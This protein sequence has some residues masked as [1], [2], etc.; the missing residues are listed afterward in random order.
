MAETTA[1]YENKI[2]KAQSWDDMKQ[3]LKELPKIT[4]RQ[5]IEE[6]CEK[7]GKSF[8]VLCG[9]AG[10]PES[11]F[12]AAVNGTRAPKKE[13][14]IRLAFALGLSLD[15]LNELLKLSKLKEL[16][17]KNTEDAIIIY[18]IKKGYDLQTIDM[19]LESQHCQMRFFRENNHG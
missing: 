6:H 2:E 7:Q 4:L 10:V 13:L 8:T 5:R 18:G 15:E 1:Q 14:I 16:Y 3:V 17:A 11:T 9:L 19:L 12:Y